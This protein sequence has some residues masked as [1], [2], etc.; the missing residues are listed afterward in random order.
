MS[1]WVSILLRWE[2][3]FAEPGPQRWLSSGAH[4]D[5]G[6]EYT[7]NHSSG[8]PR[9]E[10]TFLGARGCFGNGGGNSAV[11]FR[12]KALC[13]LGTMAASDYCADLRVGVRRRRRASG[14][15]SLETGVDR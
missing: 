15:S 2:C 10:V 14:D 4:G 5:G 9:A 3:A 13:G 12:T 7:P 11:A 6:S 8:F 1:E